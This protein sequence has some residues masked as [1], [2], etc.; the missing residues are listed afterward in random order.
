[1]RSNWWKTYDAIYYNFE[2]WFKANR[3]KRSQKRDMKGVQTDPEFLARL[4]A[5]L[6][7]SRMALD[8][9]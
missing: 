6:L 4:M 9:V 5:I 7:R 1:M 2:R 8:S 3:M